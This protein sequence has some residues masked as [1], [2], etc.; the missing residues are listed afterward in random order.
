LKVP[1]AGGST[2][3]PAMMASTAFAIGANTS[4]AKLLFE[5]GL[6]QVALSSGRPSP[7]DQPIDA[8]TLRGE[9]R[10]QAALAMPDQRHPREFSASRR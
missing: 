9:D 3:C 1:A 5:L 4:G 7:E 8:D 6:E 10:H 2:I